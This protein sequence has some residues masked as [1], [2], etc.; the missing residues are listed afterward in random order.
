MAR[1]TNG[2][3]W[4]TG[5]RRKAPVPKPIVEVLDHMRTTNIAQ[6]WMALVGLVL[7]AAGVIGFLNTPL[8][9]SST[10][11]LLATDTVHNVV[12]VLTGILA[13]GIAF[14]LKGEQQVT[15]VLGFGVLYVIIFVAVLLSPTLFG[16]FSVSAN[17]PI[18][19][20]HAAVAVVTLAVGLMARGSSTQTAS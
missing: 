1:R 18:H 2:P 11:A 10:N 19:V 3:P 5:E 14:G 8:A 16:L 17:A 7:V 6:A 20:I 13:L 9:G 12:H 4:T 15:A